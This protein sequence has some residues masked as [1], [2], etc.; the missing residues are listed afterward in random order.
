MNSRDLGG[1]ILKAVSRSFY[2]S[3]RILPRE[4]RAPV[5]LAYLL[6]RASDT[7]ADSSAASSEVRLRHLAAYNV[8]IQSGSTDG[9][10]LL[11]RDIQPDHPG[12]R[13]LIKQLDNCLAWQRSMEEADQAEIRS[14]MAKII[15][16]QTLDLQRFPEDSASSGTRALQTAAELEEYTYLVAGCVGEF[17]TRISVQHRPDYSRLPLPELT[18]LGV[19][20]GKALQLV[21]IL[22]DL[23][24]DLRQGRC[25]LPADELAAAGIEPA[26]LLTNPTLARPVFAAWLERAGELLEAGRLYIRA[27][28]PARVRIACYL[29]WYLGQKTLEMLRRQSPLETPARLKVSRKVV[30]AALLRAPVV[31][32]SNYPLRACPT[33]LPS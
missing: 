13:E 11:Q 10:G 25:Y 30:R 7:I 6:A 21:N 31:A 4:L 12:E 1:P 9:L 32:W 27:I 5:G 24:D 18:K 8:M 20:Y 3:V 22:R 14:V 16:G 17:W 2:L 28:R 33:R 23:P 15:H 29:P 19:A 26:Q